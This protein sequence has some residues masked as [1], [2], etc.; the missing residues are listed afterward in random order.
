MMIEG[1]DG[2]HGQHDRAP[3]KGEQDDPVASGRP[4]SARE[5]QQT[6]T[7]EQQ[8]GGDPDEVGYAHAAFHQA[9]RDARPAPTRGAQLPS[10]Q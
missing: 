9:Y 5:Q 7:S 10:L 4:A 3:A 8:D 1:E 2:Q 6:N